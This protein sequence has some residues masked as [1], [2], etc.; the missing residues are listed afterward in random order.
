MADAKKKEFTSPKLANRVVELAKVKNCKVLEP[1]AGDGALLKK[2]S[3][4][5]AKEVVCVELSKAHCETLA[6]LK[7]D[8]VHHVVIGDFMSK[9]AD[10]SDLFDCCVMNPP[11]TKNQDITHVRHAT[12]FVKKGG[13]IVAIIGG[14]TTRPVF[15]RLRKELDEAELKWAIHPVKEFKDVVILEINF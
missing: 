10:P 14:N 2:C 4:Y 13:K 11:Y 1:S 6:K 15:M 7:L 3:E 8:C 9:N 12:A 5:G